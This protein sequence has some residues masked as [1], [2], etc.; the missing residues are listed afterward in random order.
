VRSLK[1]GDK[2]LVSELMRN[3]TVLSEADRKWLQQVLRDEGTYKGP[4]N[5]TFSPEV[6][7][8][9]EALGGQA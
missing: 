9:M 3:P 2:Y 5:G 4:I 8:A 7:T 6:R 1:L